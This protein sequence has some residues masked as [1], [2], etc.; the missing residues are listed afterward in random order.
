MAV[1]SA[2]PG[3]PGYVELNAAPSSSTAQPQVVL[4]DPVNGSVMVH[5]AGK[6][7]APA[8]AART[9]GLGTGGTA[10][11]D[12]NATDMEGQITLVTGSAAWGTGTQGT[13]TLGT[14]RTKKVYPTISPADAATAA[15]WGTLQPYAIEASSTTWVIGFGVA[16]TAAHTLN[17]TYHLRGI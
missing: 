14:A 3:V 4:D 7:P 8:I 16:D 2:G 15:L 12:A 5:G 6:G 17:I 13:I 10:A 9:A 11:L 1:G